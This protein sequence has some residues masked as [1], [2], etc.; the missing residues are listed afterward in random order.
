MDLERFTAQSRC[1]NTGKDFSEEQFQHDLERSQRWLRLFSGATLKARFATA[2]KSKPRV[3][4]DVGGAWQPDEKRC[5]KNVE[6]SEQSGGGQPKSSTCADAPPS[7]KGPLAQTQDASSVRPKRKEATR[8]SKKSQVARASSAAQDSFKGSS[9]ARNPVLLTQ[10]AHL[11]E[12]SERPE[13]IKA[14]LFLGGLARSNGQIHIERTIAK[15]GGVVFVEVGDRHHDRLSVNALVGMSSA[16]DA[17][18][19][20]TKLNGM[21]FQA[22]PITCPGATLQ[23]RLAQQSDIK[24][25]LSRLQGHEQ[26]HDLDVISCIKNLRINS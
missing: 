7:E 4:L 2:A 12:L 6:M 10:Y 13:H 26:Q 1:K 22:C 14:V 8:P 11:C 15:F 9:T 25:W 23:V 19:V 24:M 16:Q 21:S 5:S 20:I 18:H 17:C 3:D